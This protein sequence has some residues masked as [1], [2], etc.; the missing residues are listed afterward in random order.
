MKIDYFENIDC[1]LGI[2][3]IPNESIDLTLTSPPY[4]NL[5]SYN[6]NFDFES[7]AIELFRITKKGGVVVWVC[8]DATCKGSETGT[9]FRQALFF[10]EIGFNIHDTMIYSSNKPPLNH[11]RYE[12]KFEYMFVFSRGKPKTFNPIKEPCKLSGINTSK[13]S[14]RGKDGGLYPYHS[15]EKVKEE[16]IH[17][18]IWFYET[19]NNK[20]TKD[21]IA[22]KHPAIFPEKLALDQIISWSNPGDIILDPFLGSGTV[23]KMAYLSKRHYIGF[24]IQKEFIQ[25]SEIRMEQTKNII[26]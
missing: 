21:K 14:Y 22:F 12:Q 4:D 7:I 5:R 25:L 1:L 17:G 2:K 15:N 3:K 23:A 11:N 9:S 8:G 10:K 19:G 20:S 13:R 16:K 6:S 24:D 18:N 26:I